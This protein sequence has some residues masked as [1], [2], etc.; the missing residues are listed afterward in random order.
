M[1]VFKLT[2]AKSNDAFAVDNVWRE[3]VARI[4]HK[5]AFEVEYMGR[6]YGATVDG[7]GNTVGAYGLVNNGDES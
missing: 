7:N 4:L 6:D 5:V 2:I 1:T 3:E